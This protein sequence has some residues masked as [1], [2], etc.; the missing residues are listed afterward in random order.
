MDRPGQNQNWNKRAVTYLGR[1]LEMTNSCVVVMKYTL[2]EPV[3]RTKL[4]YIS[5]NVQ[6]LGMNLKSLQGGFRLP[7]DYIHPEDRE[8]FIDAVS[9]AAKDHTNFTYR[10]R[11]VGDDGVVR[12][13]DIRSEYMDLDED[14]Y[15]IEYVFQEVVVQEEPEIRRGSEETPGWMLTK[16]SLASDELGELFGCFARAYGLYSTVVDQDG[17]ALYAPVGPDAYL[18]YYYDMFERPEMREYFESIKRS[19]MMQDEPVYTEIVGDGNPD[20]RISAAPIVVNGVYLA[21]WMLCSHDKSQASTLRL[22]SREQ[23][24]VAELVSA[25]ITRAVISD[26][27]GESGQEIEKKLEFEIRQKHVLA[28][29]Q[30]V[31]RSGG[32]GRLHTILHRASEVLEV[33]YAFYTRPKGRVKGF[34]IKSVSDVRAMVKD[35]WSPDGKAPLNMDQID[36]LNEG[37]SEEERAKILK[38]GYVVDQDSMTNRIRVTVFQ[39]LARAAI[40]M[41]IPAYEKVVGRVYFIESRKERVWTE[42]EIHFARLIGRMLGETLEIMEQENDR[43]IN[44]RTLLGIFHQLT[45]D[46]FIRDDETGKVLFVN[47]AMTKHMGMDLTGHDSRRL[48]PEGR[49][50]YES[51][52]GSVHTPEEHEHRIRTWRRYINEMNHIYDVTEI[53]VEWTDGR[54]ATAMLL[55]I[56]NEQ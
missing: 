22:A 7:K 44:S 47:D 55:R 54:P 11:L 26:K 1:A 37:F 2:N 41:P 29:L 19:T 53:P 45:I 48:I 56:V 12:N 43:E 27:H 16:E 13:V 14:Y 10:V 36:T 24:R 40:I 8:G 46:V 6:Q 31:M 38:E 52:P 3:S 49:E 35:S 32:E 30:D 33:D 42:S 4:E 23:Y 50:E 25:Y 34:A 51:Y 20:S 17:H 18:G 9:I 15:L 39:G 28:E 21:T 5:D